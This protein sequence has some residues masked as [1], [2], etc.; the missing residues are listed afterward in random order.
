[1]KSS[2]YKNDNIGRKYLNNMQK[3][4]FLK[5]KNSLLELEKYFAEL[6]VSKLKEREEEIKKETEELFLK[7]IIVSIDDMDKFEEKEMKKIRPMINTWYY[8]LINY[9]PEPIRTSVDSFKDKFINL[10]KTNTLK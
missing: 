9:I 4:Q 8:W 10:F 1:M 7:P 6:K 5:L 3:D 2:I